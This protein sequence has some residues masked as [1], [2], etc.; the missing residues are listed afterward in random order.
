MSVQV[1]LYVLDRVDLKIA[2]FRIRRLA[3][4]AHVGCPLA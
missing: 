3:S 2:Y 1:T 4:L